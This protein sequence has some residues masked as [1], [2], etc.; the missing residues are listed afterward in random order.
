MSSEEILGVP[1]KHFFGIEL[2]ITQ[3]GI[4]IVEL[5]VEAECLVLQKS[6]SSFFGRL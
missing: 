6:N 2:I 1:S 4:S 3:L 5:Q